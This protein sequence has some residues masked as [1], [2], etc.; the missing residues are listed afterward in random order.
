MV[1][2]TLD[3]AFRW[4]GLRVEAVLGPVRVPPPGM[5][6]VARAKQAFLSVVEMRPLPLVS[7]TKWV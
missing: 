2:S 6:T 1:P 4:Q 5:L 7:T 3:Q